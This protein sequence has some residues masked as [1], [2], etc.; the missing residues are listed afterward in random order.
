[1]RV[2]RSRSRAIAAV[3][4]SVIVLALSATCLAESEATAADQA[5]CAAMPAGCGAAMAQSHQCCRTAQSRLDPQTAAVSRLV[6]AVPVVHVVPVVHAASPDAAVGPVSI[7]LHAS[8][9][10]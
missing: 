2:V 8:D 1:M 9:L 6:L 5:C 4:A 10:P 7:S 3:L